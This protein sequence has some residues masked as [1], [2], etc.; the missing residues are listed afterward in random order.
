MRTQKLVLHCPECGSTDA[1]YSCTPN[2]CFNHVCAACTASFEPEAVRAGGTLPGVL[3]P[4]PL[5]D[6][7]EPTV[8]CPAC[9]STA[10]YTLA[11]GRLV[12]T[13]CAALLTLVTPS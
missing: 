10:V 2:C 8:E 12:C 5:P 9:Q 7:T 13:K 6:S 4:D 3:P 11:D 1:I